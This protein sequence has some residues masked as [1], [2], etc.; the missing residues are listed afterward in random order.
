MFI[1]LEGIEGSGKGTL[2]RSLEQYLVSKGKRVVTTREPGGTDLG[3][4]LR[5]NLLDSRVQIGKVAEMFMFAADRSHHIDT[6][7]L[8]ALEQDSFVLCDRYV[9]STF[10]YQGGGRGYDLEQ[11]R[12]LYRICCD[13]KQFWP[14]L[15]FILDLPVEDGL[16]RARAR[17]AKDGIEEKEGKFEALALAFHQRVRDTYLMLSRTRCHYRIIDASGSRESVFEQ[18]LHYLHQQVHIE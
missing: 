12:T 9:D 5:A 10:A 1:T 15:T 17:N 16:R 6:V 7:I 8:P 18:A 14:D 4:S 3:K 11:L 13:D 2:L